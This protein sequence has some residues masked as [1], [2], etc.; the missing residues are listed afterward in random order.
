MAAPPE[1]SLIIL[2]H[3]GPTGSPSHL[4]FIGIFKLSEFSLQVW[5]LTSAISVAEIGPRMDSTLVEIMEI[6][7]RS[8]CF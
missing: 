7:V 3:N 2:A 4:N 6:L 8:L 5:V 1:N